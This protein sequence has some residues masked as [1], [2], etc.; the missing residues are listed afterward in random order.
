MSIQIYYFSGTGNS[1]HISRE[2]QR[3]ITDTVIV[4]IIRVLNSDKIETISET[5]GLVF[6]I[7]CLGLP[8]PVTQFLQQADLRSATYIFAITTRECSSSVFTAI[9]KILVKQTKSLHASFSIEMPEKYIPIFEIPSQEEI[10]RME[11]KMQFRLDSITSV[12]ANRQTSLEHDPKTLGFFI[13]HILSP[14]IRFVFS[15][16][17]YFNM[18]KAFYSD[19]KCTGCGICEKV[20]LSNRVQV[21]NNKPKWSNTVKCIFCFACLHYCPVQ[22]IQ[23]RKRKTTTRGRYHHPEINVDDIARQKLGI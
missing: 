13:Y 3:R 22:S 6:P 5:I 18:E 15:K 12:I 1:L 20:C 21:V 23:I 2:L 17:R 7:H 10:M 9:D 4:P 14:I 8:I 19:S 11:A 16:T